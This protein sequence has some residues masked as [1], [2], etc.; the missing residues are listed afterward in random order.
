MI[1]C[2]IRPQERG[3]HPGVPQIG[4]GAE[5]PIPNAIG[6]GSQEPS[7]CPQQFWPKGHKV[8]LPG[9]TKRERLHFTPQYRFCTLNGAEWCTWRDQERHAEHL[10]VPKS[11]PFRR[12]S[13]KLK[14]HSSPKE[15]RPQCRII[16]RKLCLD[17]KRHACRGRVLERGKGL[18]QCRSF[19]S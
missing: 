17:Q 2:T 7:G 13:R 15:S 19:C 18:L 10:A 9:R 11:R 6:Q 8:T 4:F 12:Q 5:L 3:Q 14:P 1:Q 16:C